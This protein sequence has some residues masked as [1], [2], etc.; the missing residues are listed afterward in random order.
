MW[1]G[2]KCISKSWV[3]GPTSKQETACHAEPRGSSFQAWVGKVTGNTLAAAYK[4]PSR[5]AAAPGY[6][7]R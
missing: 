5:V 4:P 6:P 1:S 3:S 2:G 7:Y